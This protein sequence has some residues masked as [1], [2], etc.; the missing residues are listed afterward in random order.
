MDLTTLLRK[1]HVTVFRL[2][3]DQCP[4]QGRMILDILPAPLQPWHT[5]WC[6]KGDRWEDLGCVV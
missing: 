1:A 5:A 6:I 2:V 3:H 4:V